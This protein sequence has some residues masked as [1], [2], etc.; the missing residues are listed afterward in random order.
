M[1]PR[2]FKVTNVNNFTDYIGNIPVVNSIATV[3]E[4]SQL[5]TID[6]QQHLGDFKF[7]EIIEKPDEQSNEKQTFDF[8]EHDVEGRSGNV[9]SDITVNPSVKKPG[10]PRNSN[11][12]GSK[13]QRSDTKNKS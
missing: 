10:R 4:E 2:K 1:K 6:R 7:E 5:R 11:R 3:T 8:A 13:K 12:R 9:E